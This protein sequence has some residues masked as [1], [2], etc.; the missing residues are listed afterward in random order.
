[1]L[2]SIKKWIRQFEKA[3]KLIECVYRWIEWGIKEEFIKFTIKN[4]KFTKA[5]L[6][7][8]EIILE[9]YKLI[10]TS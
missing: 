9:H 10:K 3:I 5:Q 1:M 8:F 6:Y 7:A 4:N 2:L